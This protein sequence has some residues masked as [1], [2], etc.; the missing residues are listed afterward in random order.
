[1]VAT[2]SVIGLVDRYRRCSAYSRASMTRSWPVPHQQVSIL[3]PPRK[4]MFQMLG[5]FAEL[6]GIFENESM[7]GSRAPRRTVRS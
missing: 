7:L 2:W 1:M 4:R 6:T 3:Q 5:V